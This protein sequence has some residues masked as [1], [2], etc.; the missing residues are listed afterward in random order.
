MSVSG[1]RRVPRKGSWLFS[2]VELF[3]FVVWLLFTGITGYYFGYDPSAAKCPEVVQIATPAAAA[4][5]APA[6]V[7][8]CSAGTAVRPEVFTTDFPEGGYSLAELKAVWGCSHAT[9]TSKDI[10][11]S[12]LSLAK[13][14]WKSILTVEPKAFFDRY[15]SQY[16]ADTRASQPV[17]VFSHKPLDA[18]ENLNDVCKVLDIAVVP[19]RE[20]V[21]V[22][23]TE[24][25]H[26]VASYHMLHAERDEKGQFVLSANFI[27]GRALPTEE[28]YALARAMLLDYFKHTETVTN[29]VKDVP[30]YGNGKVRDTCYDS[31][32]ALL[33]RLQVTVGVLV[34]DAEDLELFLNSFAS[35]RKQGVSPNKFAVFTTSDDVVQDLSKTGIKVV[36]LPSLREVGKGL[37][38]Y[39]RAF[40]QTWLAFAAANSLTKMM[41]VSPATVWKE[42]PDNIAKA[43]PA[44][45]TLWAF[46]G[47]KDGRAAPFFI[48]FDFFIIT[49]VERPVHFLHELI[50]HFDLILAWKSL[51]AVAA[52]RLT[53]NNS[54]YGTTTYILPP[55]AVLH[56]DIMGNDPIKIRA[57]AEAAEADQPMVITLAK[58]E[59]AGKTKQLLLD[60]GLWF[61]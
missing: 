8:P 7:H 25:Y 24:T 1:K 29:A 3:F 39:R 61:L 28:H 42:R 19:D 57:A 26:D 35:A 20:G 37:G 34:D 12:S 18:F 31:C 21:C 33:T 14:K 36:S 50:L 15:L 44:V 46:K 48:S 6:A 40:L 52:Y 58:Q 4:P 30:K 45:E 16:P 38:A 53:E 43:F 10:F 51:D 2:A 27:D 23:V 41:W 49:A 17:V 60:S 47:R 56:G 32:C 22:A 59:E 5:T 11:P 55:F 13:T 9:N 54:R